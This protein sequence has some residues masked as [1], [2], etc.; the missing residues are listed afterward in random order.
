MLRHIPQWSGHFHIRLTV[1]ILPLIC[2]L[3]SYVHIR[4]TILN[5]LSTRGICM[6]I[7]MWLP[8]LCGFSLLL[9]NYWLYFVPL[10]STSR[11]KDIIFSVMYTVV[12]PLLN[13]FIYRL[14][15]RDM[16]DALERLFNKAAVLSQWYL[17]IFIT[18]TGSHIAPYPTCLILSPDWNEYTL[19]IW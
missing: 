10:S 9:N 16:K 15:N 4:A 6:W 1:I 19:N 14:R 12:I 8:P 3:V 17:L 7:Y 5:V 11:D 2:I 18:D 13:P